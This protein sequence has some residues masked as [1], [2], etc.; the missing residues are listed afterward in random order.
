MLRGCFIIYICLISNKLVIETNSVQG[1]IWII[2][3][4]EYKVMVYFCQ[5]DPQIKIECDN[6]TP[7]FLWN[8]GNIRSCA[9]HTEISDLP[10]CS[11]IHIWL[12]QKFN[13]GHCWICCLIIRWWKMEWSSF[14]GRGWI[15][16]HCKP[17]SSDADP[18]SQGRGLQF[19]TPR[20]WQWI[21]E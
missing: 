2:S 21:S 17:R 9:V 6:P 4:C 11:T 7:N 8:F 10:G 19:K 13:W 15:A 3:Y 20:I 18:R 1:L 12:L 5:G 14:L 16:L